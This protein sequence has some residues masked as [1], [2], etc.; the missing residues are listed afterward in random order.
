MR[1]NKR[2][3]ERCRKIVKLTAWKPKSWEFPQAPAY[4]LWER[5]GKGPKGK[6]RAVVWHL[7]PHLPWSASV[8][9]LTKTGHWRVGLDYVMGLKTRAG[10]LRAI[11]PWLIFRAGHLGISK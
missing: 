4:T 5:H 7:G 6:F 1:L 11:T 8:D 2:L 10:A 9:S 3:L